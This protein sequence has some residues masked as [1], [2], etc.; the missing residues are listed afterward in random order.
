V[1]FLIR[2]RGADAFANLNARGDEILEGHYAA[3]AIALVTHADEELLATLL[4]HGGE[5]DNV[6]GDA[7]AFIVLVDQVEVTGDPGGLPGATAVDEGAT[8][9]VF[10]MPARG[11]LGH[12][13]LTRYVKESDEWV[14]GRALFVID[15]SQSTT[16]ARSTGIDLSQ[17]PAIAVWDRG[18]A[19]LT[20]ISR[21]DWETMLEILYAG[22]SDFYARHR[23]HR[24][25]Q[26][27][28]EESETRSRLTELDRLENRARWETER[29]WQPPVR[30][31]IE[32]I[33][34]GARSCEEFSA[35]LAEAV[36]STA[37]ATTDLATDDARRYWLLQT[38]RRRQRI[39]YET[40]R[41]A[42]QV[43]AEPPESDRFAVGEL[44]A[45]IAQALGGEPGGFPD[46]ADLDAA[47]EHCRKN[48][49]DLRAARRVVSSAIDDR[50][51]TVDR[52]TFLAARLGH[53]LPAGMADRTAHERRLVEIRDELSSTSPPA[54]SQLVEAAIR[55]N[56]KEVRMFRIKLGAD[57]TGA[58][59]TNLLGAISALPI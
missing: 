35:R 55:R 23:G 32:G 2:S 52:R 24:F 47:I 30:V 3:Y 50:L 13:A 57:K 59:L 5:I 56:R 6:T 16:F 14:T 42:K 15:P 26:L 25:L 38:L 7:V 39:A 4:R 54:L 33:F 44:W 48:E 40:L 31:T 36:T 41:A 17:L 28:R 20:L 22:I 43:G 9:Q 10:R 8:E 29:G 45:E 21:A 18:S 46:P 11:L 49:M 51:A 58:F 1:G 53:E 27:T 34:Q 37:S 12:R 19:E